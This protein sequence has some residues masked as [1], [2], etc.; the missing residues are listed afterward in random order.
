MVT[1]SAPT[2][3]PS[4]ILASTTVTLAANG[5]GSVTAVANGIVGAYA[6]SADVAGVNTI[7]WNLTNIVPIPKTY[8]VTS[9]ADSGPGTLR[10][11]ITQ[12]DQDITFDTI[13]FDPSVVGTITLASALPDLSQTL[14]LDGP[15][16][17]VLTVARSGA[18]GTPAFS[19]FTVPTW[20]A[21][22]ISGL[23]VSGGNDD[24]GGGISN[25]GTMTVADSTISGNNAGDLGGGGISNSGTMTVADSTIS[26]NDVSY[27]GGGG[28]YNS[29]TL[30]VTDSTISGNE[31]F[32]PGGGGIFNNGTLA[33]THSL[34]SGNHT[35]GRGDD[36]GG[37]DNQGT[38][39]LAD[40][41]LTGN[42]EDSIDN[43]GRMTVTD[44]AISGNAG[45]GVFNLSGPLTVTGCTISGNSGDGVFNN[46]GTLTVTGCTI[47]GNSGDGVFNSEVSVT[48]GALT[49]TN[50]TI[51]ENSET[52]IDNVAGAVTLADCTLGGNEG[53]SLINTSSFLVDVSN[54]LLEPIYTYLPGRVS[55]VA[56]IFAD[57]AGG[58]I[59]NDSLST[60]TSLG[61]NLFTDS[62]KVS[63]APSDLVNTNPLLAPLGNYGGPTQ[64]MALLPGSPAIDAGVA[65][66]GIT[67]DQRGIAR[68]Q[69]TAPDIGAFQSRGFTLTV[70]GG[71]GQSTRINTS[72][73]A[74]LSLSV[75]S[76]DGEPVAGGQ[77]TLKAP[78]T[79]PTAA[80][81]SHTVTLNEHGLASVTA[82][83][84]GITGAYPITAG[85]V[86]ANTVV[87][88]LANIL[89]PPEVVSV[90]RLG[91]SLQPTTYV[92]TFSEALDPTSASN[93]KNYSLLLVGPN[94]HPAPHAKPIPVT[95]AV[96]SPSGLTV[97][98]T[99]S[100]R[101][102]LSG[103]YRLTVSDAVK[104]LDGTPL[105]GTYSGQPGSAFTTVLQG[106]AIDSHQIAVDLNTKG[107]ETPRRI[108]APW[109]VSGA[110]TWRKE[111]CGKDSADDPQDR[112]VRRGHDGRD[113]L[114]L[115]KRR[116][117]SQRDGVGNVFRTDRHSGE[118]DRAQAL[119]VAGR[120]PP[121]AAPRSDRERLAVG[122]GRRA[123]YLGESAA[124]AG[125]QRLKDRRVDRW[126]A[127]RRR[128]RVSISRRRTGSTRSSSTCPTA[129]IRSST[130]P[131]LNPRR[132][133]S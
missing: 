84:N 6:V 107:R 89:I 103:Y 12:A 62:P 18:S 20:A 53:G 87:W 78:T 4:A 83:A 54:G 42:S 129:T 97:T 75:T 112:G 9:L 121:Q 132:R 34:I 41:T 114:Y 85:T 122:R 77:V 33:V 49:I 65:V 51:S 38:A 32:Y 61:H 99:S 98:I 17:S 19:V 37:I 24:S 3:G 104:S 60:F 120:D 44:C 79:G 92:L 115:Q 80:L 64:T 1:L 69:G 86:G 133:C 113:G 118:G 15:G 106:F 88:N 27:L 10:A 128:N 67:T 108:G 124:S 126:I 70:T 93:P 8:T 94:G 2:T 21:V 59:S 101:L 105:D 40:C 125:S 46:V 55:A 71:N 117:T 14:T 109:G 91:F 47:S 26:G 96:Y 66:A 76:P 5:Q 100:Q 131:T 7:S 48:P 116:P 36:G 23:T 73:S 29:G 81:G 111:R 28:I 127:R 90:R 74:P 58:N 22:T 130:S 56:S 13:N 31:S 63:L 39:S 30:T 45:D 110:S 25:S 16:A 68:P 123:G 102:R 119:R 95:S 52:G 43:L 72:F 35:T 57:A 50:C 82:T 11:A